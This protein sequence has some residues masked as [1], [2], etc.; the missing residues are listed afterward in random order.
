MTER[1]LK[2]VSGLFL[3]FTHL[4]IMGEIIVMRFLNG[5][6]GPEFST[7][8]GIIIPMFSGYTAAIIAFF[9]KDRH[10]FKDTTSRVNAIYVS[11]FLLLPFIFSSIV[12]IAI[13]LQAHNQAFENFED[14]KSFVMTIESAFAIYVGMFVYSLFQKQTE[15]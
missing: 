14:F 2:Y 4:F 6:D 9:I 15:S 10:N 3:I 13:W 1:K 7:I 12:A 8:F 5:F 11:L